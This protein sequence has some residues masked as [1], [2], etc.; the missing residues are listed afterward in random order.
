[1]P[2]GTLLSLPI[3]SNDVH[4]YSEL[5][6]GCLNYLDIIKQLNPKTTLNEGSHCHLDPDLRANTLLRTKEWKPA[7]GQTGSSLTELRDNGVKEGDLF[8]FFG[9]FKKTEYHN[10]QL[11]YIPKSPN[12]HV[13]YGYMQIGNIVDSV[14]QIPE[15]LKYH[16][17]VNLN[18]YKEAWGK[19]QNS[20]YLPSERLSFAS[21]LSGSGIFTFRDEL[22]LTKS[23]YSRSR[24]EFPI[25][26][27]GTP[28]SHNP[29]GWKSDY[30]Q[31]AARG[32]E[33]IMEGSP[34][35]MDWV[36]KVIKI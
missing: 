19:K 7:F 1:L 5:S 12:L 11:R 29:N 25:S 6:W 22:V 31:S 10:E 16:P 3:P 32:Q 27:H 9:W 2:D 30:F 26:M 4:K 14:C 28:I 24:W 18:N 34:A 36:R 20:I 17:H 23:G 21:G 33:F 15:W 13:I 35:V 8:L